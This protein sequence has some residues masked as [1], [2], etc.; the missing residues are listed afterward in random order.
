MAEIIEKNN[1]PK[2]RRFLR[3]IG[4][5]SAFA[6][7]VLL[8]L[9]LFIV[10]LAYNHNFRSFV[11]SKITAIASTQL[12]A[13]IEIEDIHLIGFGGIKLD[14]VRL[15]TGGD[16]LVSLSSIFIDISLEP[17]LRNKIHL[18]KVVLNS[19][20]IKLLR[21]MSD[22]TWNYDRIVPYVE[23]PETNQKTDLTIRL[24]KLIINDGLFYMVD[25]L[26][27][28]YPDNMFNA[29]AMLFDNLNLDL[30]ANINLATN[31]FSSKIND[32]SLKDK[33][34][35]I[36]LEKFSANAKLNP[37]GIFLNST[38]IESEGFV[39]NLDAQITNF[40]VFGAEEQQII[41]NAIF[42]VVFQVDNYNNDFSKH[43]AEIPIEI[44]FN[45]NV[46]LTA[47]G[48]L[49]DLKVKQLEIDFGKSKLKT[50]GLLK[51]ALSGD[52]TYD[53]IFS[54]LEI[55]RANLLEL[56]P[57]LKDV[58]LP[59][60][61]TAKFKTLN[62][63]GNTQYLD[64]QIDMLSNAGNAK[65]NAKLNFANDL[66]YDINMNIASLDL[67]RITNDIS[68]KSNINAKLLVKGVGSD[69]DNMNVSVDLKSHSS[70]IYDFS[71]DLLELKANY[72]SNDS[73]IVDRLLLV[74]DN[75]EVLEDFEM[76]DERNSSLLLQG[77]ADLSTEKPKYNL[78]GV[79]KSLNLKKIFKNSD[80][81]N[82]I[83]GTLNLD[84]QSFDIDNLVATLHTSLDEVLF[85]TKSM[86]PFDLSISSQINAD[87]TR[88]YSVES[89]FFKVD[90]FGKFT[91]S[92]LIKTM[93]LQ[94]EYLA[95]FINYKLADIFP[96]I[97]SDSSKVSVLD[98]KISFPDMSF[99]IIANVSDVS[100][101]NLFLKG[102][103]IMS[104][105]SV[106][107]T[108]LSSS[109]DSYI[110]IDSV[111]IN[112]FSIKSD[113]LNV[114]A[115]DMLLQSTM[116]ISLVDSIP[117][118]SFL[119]AKVSSPAVLLFN[120]MSI[121]R[122]SASI[123]FDGNSIDFYASTKFENMLDIVAKGAFDVTQPAV[124]LSIDSLYVAYYD[125]FE[126][127]NQSPLELILQ[128]EKIEISNFK[129]YGNNSEII[130]LTGIIDDNVAKS[131]NLS[132][133]DMPLREVVKLAPMEMQSNMKNI[134]GIINKININIE[135]ALLNPLIDMD[136][137]IDSISFDNYYIGNLQLNVAHNDGNITGTANI[138]NP[139]R[140]RNPNYLDI[141]ISS[142]PIFLGL[143]TN[144]SFFSETREVDIQIIA[145][146]FPL[147]PISPFVP[148]VSKLQGLVESKLTIMGHLPDKL[149][150]QG[151]AV[152]KNAS[153]ILDNTNIAY[154]ASGTVS[155]DTDRIEIEK[156][157]LR[158]LAS[159]LRD[160]A[161]E[162]TGH[163]TLKDFSPEYLDIS[164][165]AN[166]FLVL[167]EASQRAMPGLYGT[168]I[169][170]TEGRPLR[171]Y[172]T[173]QE[174]NLEG[175]VVV[176]NAELKMPQIINQ[177]IIRT[178]FT[179]EVKGSSRLYKFTSQVDSSLIEDDVQQQS[180]G[181]DFA[182][183][184]NYDLSISIK[185]FTILIDMGSIGEIYAKIGTRD[186]SIP[187]RYVKNR[188]E[189]APKLYSG[190][191]ELKEG[192]TIKIFRFMETKGYIS[193]PTG[194]LDN[195]TLDLEARYDGSFVEGNITSYYSVFLYMTGTK[196]TPKIALD[197]SIN[198]EQAVG[199]PNKIEED[200]FILLA[201]GRPRGIGGGMGSSNI[202]G[203]GLN[204]GISQL[205][206]KSLTDLLLSTGVIQS[207]DVRFEGE[208]F[209]TAQVN[210]A[211]TV[212]GIGTWTIGGNIGDLSNNYEVSFDIPIAV[213]S[214]VLNNF[215][216]QLSKS[217]NVN[218]SSQLRDAKDY[219]VKIKFGGSW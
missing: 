92:E 165:K 142:L 22:S 170:G 81:P 47:N 146:D 55:T 52:V 162:V 49:N 76:F 21:R 38:R 204:M 164:I 156:I 50:S 180:E 73:L 187:M 175:D 41:D 144:K 167:S 101:I 197:Y 70:D 91:P 64:A 119:D 201:T 123:S 13:D 206:S 184:I 129:L 67:A 134:G 122:P 154:N 141:N 173:M 207:A 63:S 75:P 87:S 188:N 107:M 171:F 169:I 143:D 217:T 133:S 32:I 106:K 127:N 105:F 205:A 138:M 208:G 100:P 219:E 45:H 209:E 103:D 131:F 6:A 19:P 114:R 198:G 33:T 179:Y 82:H 5:L 17:L 128:D 181:T 183:L 31:E 158:N 202:V 62:L 42:D 60:F 191:L 192:S 115:N 85:D 218:I 24:K 196:E 126:F 177:Q 18:N 74:I 200:A 65:G 12:T 40:N 3:I 211:G 185:N 14:E 96:N 71:Y 121:Q 72:R 79:F 166:R 10:F 26:A 66:K 212:S 44:G 84:G 35:G 8:L 88:I 25:S 130:E 213:R 43:F 11:I 120:G 57:F 139:R 160:G 78:N 118:F 194:S 53:F 190:E 86:M 182:E 97:S 90:L 15:L 102:Y 117:S 51:D 54:E 7:I 113:N 145:D 159:D 155:I 1:V 48:N 136:F 4:Y 135:G 161:A 150:Y 109:N 149:A 104:G 83:S 110:S 99:E 95:S 195:P 193:F 112:N 69:P 172:G 27:K 189:T 59:D 9:S 132:V 210:L 151:G 140:Q 77:S 147:Q 176:W 29:S 28:P 216:L 168:F 214:K 68:L 199:D 94:G 20:E 39:A 58:Q 116:N 34:S 61:V 203:E 137:S 174:P 37:D 163:I 125:V 111:F 124:K 89:D 215:I 16:T 157:N 80:L 108:M 46:K 2:K 152:L 23:K 98:D 93:Q 148:N 30:S 178:T 36:F 153:F 186:P 56:L